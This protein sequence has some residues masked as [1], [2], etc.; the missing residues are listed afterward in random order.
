MTLQELT[1]KVTD[2]TQKYPNAL[3]G[4]SVKFSFP[5]EGVV[6]IDQQLQVTNQDKEA[7]CTISTAMDELDKII[8]G[9]TN[10]MAAVMFGKLKISGNMGVAMKLQNLFA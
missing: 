4:S 9:E 3:E 1:Q 10:A 6:H 5:G 7:E 2:L 8:K